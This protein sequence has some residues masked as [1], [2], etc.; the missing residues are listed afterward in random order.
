MI[1]RNL[2]A[3]AAALAFAPAFGQ[4][5]G[6]VTTVDGV[7]TVITSTG[8]AALVAGSPL[9]NGARIVTTS[10]SSVTLSLNSG[11][12]V[13][14]PP[15]HAV[16]VTSN[17]TC[18]EL[19]AAVKPVMPVASAPSTAVMGQAGAGGFGGNAVVAVWAAAIALA[20]IDDASHDDDVVPLSGR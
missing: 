14:V 20:I 6:T 7:A 3:I 5:L 8:G 11:C 10:A 19:Q 13:T 16:T 2:L 17:L 4:T 9:V 1:T 12:I 15:A 18:K